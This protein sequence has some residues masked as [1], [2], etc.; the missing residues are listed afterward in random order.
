MNMESIWLRNAAEFRLSEQWTL[1][2]ELSYYSAD[3][4][5]RDA[6]FYTYAAPGKITRGIT[7]ISHDH[8][9]WSER[10]A[11]R[12]DGYVGG[13]RNRFVAGAEYMQT[14]FGSNR[15]FGDDTKGVDIFAPARGYYPVLATVPPFYSLTS[16]TAD[17][18]T[19]AAFAEHAINLTS[20]WIVAAGI[21]HET[22][23]I[24][25]TILDETTGLTTR[26]GNDL[27]ATTWRIGSTYEVFKGT[28]FF[29]QYTEA[30]TPVSSALMIAS[31][32][33]VRFK[34]T[35]GNSV[36][37]G[38]KS[39]WAGGRVT[40][41][42]SV[43][44]IEQDDIITRDPAAPAVA[45]QGGS[46]RSRGIEVETSVS[47]TDRWNLS[48]SG[49]VIDSEFT[50]LT[51]GAGK[52]LAGNRPLNTVP[53]AWSAVTTYRL[54]ALPATL[55]AQLVGVGPFFTSN[56]NVYEAKERTVLDAWVAFDLGKGTL[57]L[58]GRNLTDEFYAE[59]A[60]YN[61]TSLYVGAPRSFDVTYSVKW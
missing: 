42:A 26:F 1:R 22:I 60:D 5:W 56:A 2:N 17:H 45:I 37:A 13:L 43:Y 24:D 50:D 58:R 8:E 19:K 49:T 14:S 53:W 23:D 18:A 52:S 40:T 3:R 20:S 39:T 31:P 36:E 35:T 30:V 46:Q 38:V 61:A 44:Q 54:Q 59:W 32:A 47:L 6:D 10:L 34:L 15:H 29:A 48:L 55:G 28:T 33:N 4:L 27:G 25:R 57:R 41:T 7:M 16:Q 12:F 9:F 51:D 21:R 11:L